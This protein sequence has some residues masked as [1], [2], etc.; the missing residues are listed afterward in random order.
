MQT[1]D[2]KP[3]VAHPFVKNAWYAAMWSSDLPLDQLVDRFILEE[4]MVFYRRE[5]GSVVALLDRCPH[6]FA[7]LSQGKLIGGGRIQCGYHGLEFS[8]GGRCVRNPYGNGHIPPAA[9]VRTFP[10]VERHSMIWVWPGDGEPNFSAI[11]DFGVIDGA[12]GEHV[13]RLDCIRIRA[14][15][16]LIIDNL[17]DPSHAFFLHTGV[18][19]H[20]A[21]STLD[22]KVTY[23]ADGVDVDKSS[24]NVPLPSLVSSLLANSRNGETIWA[25]KWTHIHWT[26]PSTLLLQSGT[27]PS[28]ADRSTGTGYFGFHLLTPETNRSTLYYFTSVRWNVPDTETAEQAASIIE[29]LS[30]TRKHVF[31]SEDAVMIEAQQERIDLGGGA[32]R[33]ALL[34]VDE[35][36]VRYGK[37]LDALIDAETPVGALR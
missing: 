23:T 18:L 17:L 22:L 32:P 8:D 5:D 11:P 1:S 19:G 30:V 16:R 24:S 28:G 12:R 2:V 29:N 25:D 36:P 33:P 15:Y 31:E 35:G 7:P 21:P 34:A 10:T 9:T 6:R 14:N 4:P 26:P 20:G 27:C 3:R 37:I 13:A